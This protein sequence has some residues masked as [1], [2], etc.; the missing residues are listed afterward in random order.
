MAGC[1]EGRSRMRAEGDRGAIWQALWALIH[2]E[3]PASPVR[4]GI[5][6]LILLNTVYVLFGEPEAAPAVRVRMCS[7]A[8]EEDRMHA[9]KSGFKQAPASPH[10]RE[11]E[12]ARER[13]GERACRHGD[14]PSPTRSRNSESRSRLHVS[15]A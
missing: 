8:F 13:E 7:S 2:V 11:R 5:A 4:N 12:R 6:V 1:D 3:L 10:A 9:H 15:P 14:L